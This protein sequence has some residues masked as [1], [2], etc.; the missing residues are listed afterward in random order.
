MLPLK[1]CNVRVS[2]TPDI[3]QQWSQSLVLCTLGYKKLLW[4]INLQ[5]LLPGNCSACGSCSSRCSPSDATCYTSG[6]DDNG[7]DN[8]DVNGGGNVVV[9][10]IRMM[11]VIFVTG[12]ALVDVHQVTQLVIQQHRHLAQVSRVYNMQLLI[13]FIFR[14]VKY[15]LGLMH[16]NK[17]SM[18]IKWRHF[19]FSDGNDH[20]DSQNR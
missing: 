18:G 19:L 16:L 15:P 12:H 17:A 4:S 3:C 14:T 8:D 20:F 2:V 11:M 13:F 5:C 7:D 9:V 1:C 6:A 10:L